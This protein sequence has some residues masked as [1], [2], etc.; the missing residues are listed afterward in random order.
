[1]LPDVAL[2]DIGM[3]GVNGY[4]LAQALRELPHADAVFLVAATGWGT[5]QDLETLDR[6]L[7]DR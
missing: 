4:Q 5:Q 7:A 6:L 1:M 3:P 2:L